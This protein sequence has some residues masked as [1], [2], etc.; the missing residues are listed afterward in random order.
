MSERGEALDRLSAI[1]PVDEKTVEG[2]DSPRAKDLLVK[3]TATSRNDLHTRRPLR[4]PL[5]LAISLAVVAAVT[6]AAAWVLTRIVESP[7][8]VSCYQAV[9]LNADVAAAPAGGPA[10]AEACVPVWQDGVLVNTKIAP[11]KTVPPLLGCVADNGSLAV[12][13][14]DDPT[15][16]ST[17]NFAYPDPVNQ[18]EADLLRA[19]EDQLIEYFQSAECRPMTAAET[20]VRFILDRAG[21]T[22][23]SI[24]AQPENPG[25]PCASHSLS[26]D[27]RTVILVP[28]PEN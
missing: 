27:A 23:W 19:V 4:K 22:D 24:Q 11:S 21:L 8:A 16:C 12:F 2:P 20:E 7:N 25:R 6:I 3:I 13:P 14:T 10:T 18:D 26:E 17:F 15:V 5:R 1:N 9:D 28:I